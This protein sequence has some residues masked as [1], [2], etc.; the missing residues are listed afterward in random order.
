[1]FHSP[2]L[3]AV[4][5]NS[6]PHSASKELLGNTHITS[7]DTLRG[8]AALSVVI[9]HY[10]LAYGLPTQRTQNAWV[11][12]E[13]EILAWWD[14]AVPVSLFFVL[15]GFVLSLKFFRVSEAPD[16]NNYHW[17][18]YVTSRFCR[19]W[20]PY[21]AVL[22]LSSLMQRWW[23]ISKVSTVPASSDWFQSLWQNT[24]T[25]ADIAKQSFLLRVVNSPTPAFALVPQAWTLALELVMSIVIPIG[26]L[27]AARSS[28]WLVAVALFAVKPLGVSFFLLHFVMGLLL[29]KHLPYLIRLSDK[30]R[31]VPAF[32]VL[33][34]LF[35]F[36]VRYCE[37]VER[38]LA[39]RPAQTWI[40]AGV[41]SA[42]L[43]FYVLVTPKVQAYLTFA[44]LR[45]VGKISYSIY[46]IH[47]A[48]LLCIVPRSLLW[49]NTG[50]LAYAASWTVG[51]I[52]LLGVSVVLSAIMYKYVELPTIALGKW[53]SARIT[54]R[55]HI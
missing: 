48:V 43:L 8:L 53:I 22:V 14:G 49:L 15:S 23:G 31:E 16:L 45:Y 26:V 46:L 40:V 3:P 36:V 52:V 25:L 44:P 28:W 13:T 4:A 33:A 55:D 1:M 20:F 29:A 42:L 51:L 6:S 50:A 41:A 17:L 37:P 5:V 34:S 18:P 21:A 11:L 27:V 19:I 35:L 9:G 47:F 2:R 54:L 39:T 24:P 32:A 30:R 12:T 10:V 7:L 38:Y